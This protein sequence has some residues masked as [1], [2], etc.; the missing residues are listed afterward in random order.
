ME[1]YLINE[2]LAIWF[3]FFCLLAHFFILALFDPAS[4]LIAMLSI[5]ILFYVLN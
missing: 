2:P 1:Q 5:A 3:G 4:I